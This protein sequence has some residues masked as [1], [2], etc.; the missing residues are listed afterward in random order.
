MSIIHH[1]RLTFAAPEIQHSYLNMYLLNEWNCKTANS[2]ARRYEVNL[3]ISWPF[4]SFNSSLSINTDFHCIIQTASEIPQCTATLWFARWSAAAPAHSVWVTALSALITTCLLWIY[5][6]FTAGKQWY[7]HAQISP[8]HI[9]R[10]SNTQYKQVNTGLVFA[11]FSS[12]EK[13]DAGT[14][15]HGGSTLKVKRL[16]NVFPRYHNVLANDPFLCGFYVFLEVC[17][18]SSF[19][20]P[21]FKINTEVT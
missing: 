21:G 2:W 6:H 4:K 5:P 15:T 9:S 12:H 1:D 20:Q 14:L 3:K 19:L 17:L 16:K 13:G 18:L 10:E 8:Y 7:G 11:S